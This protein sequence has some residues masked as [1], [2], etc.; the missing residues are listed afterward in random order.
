M[1][2]LIDGGVGSLIKWDKAAYENS[3]DHLQLPFLQAMNEALCSLLTSKNVSI[4]CCP[5]TRQ[6]I[7]LEELQS[8]KCLWEDL[9]A[10]EPDTHKGCTMMHI[11]HGH[12][13]GAVEYILLLYASWCCLF[14]VVAVS[15]AEQVV[16]LMDSVLMARECGSILLHNLEK[17]LKP[18]SDLLLLPTNVLQ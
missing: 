5:Y 8:T 10:E 16:K 15:Y 14:Q 2:K 18:T 17:D 12:K 3:H 13:Y 1:T 4:N 6:I 11:V 7:L 9:N